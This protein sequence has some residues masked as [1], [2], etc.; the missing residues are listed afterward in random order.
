MKLRIF[1]GL[2]NYFPNGRMPSARARRA[3][4][5]DDQPAGLSH[6]RFRPGA[7]QLLGAPGKQV[8]GGSDPGQLPTSARVFGHAY[9]RRQRQRG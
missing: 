4:D 8:G 2:R 7:E 1:N 6:R 3:G 9:S 5:W